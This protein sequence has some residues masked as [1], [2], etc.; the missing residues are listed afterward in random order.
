MAYISQ[1]TKAIGDSI[2]YEDWNTN[3]SN[4]SDHESRIANIETITQKVVVFDFPIYSAGAAST[5]TGLTIW[6]S[7]LNFTLTSCKI[8][9]YDV[10]GASGVL[11]LDIKKL[12][13][14]PSHSYTSVF[15]T[16]PSVNFP[17]SSNYTES[18]N[19]IFDNGLKDIVE[20]DILKVDLTSIP[21]TLVKCHIFLVGEI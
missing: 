10:S 21:S 4:A 1:T 9:V 12:T 11:E 19:A 14:P 16:K 5:I 13:V 20:G 2:K 17:V 18:T 7:P 15:T 6:K 3:I 8:M